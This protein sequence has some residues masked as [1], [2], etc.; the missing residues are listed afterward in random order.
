MEVP[1]P[2]FESEPQ[3]RPMYATGAATLHPLTLGTGLRIKPAPPKWSKLLQIL[4]LLHHRGNSKRTYFCKISILLNL[5][6]FV[7]WLRTRS[8]LVNVLGTLR[9]EQFSAA[10]RQCVRQVSIRSCWLFKS[11]YPNSFL[12]TLSINQGERLLKYSTIMLDLSISPFSSVHFV[13][14]TLNMLSNAHTI[15]TVVSSDKLTTLSYVFI[16]FI[17]SGK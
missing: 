8:L 3:L 13:P 14:R 9:T 2:G 16:V 10:L 15:R 5:L 1:R 6:K 11:P 7:L 12:S 17:K 4:N